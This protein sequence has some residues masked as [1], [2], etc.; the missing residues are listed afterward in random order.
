MQRVRWR[1]IE[2]GKW[3]TRFPAGGLESVQVGSGRWEGD[4]YEGGIHETSQSL[5][6]AEGEVVRGECEELGSIRRVSV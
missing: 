6:D 5:S 3:L 4:P 2:C 1:E